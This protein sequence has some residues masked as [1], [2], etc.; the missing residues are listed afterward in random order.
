M[1]TAA[2]ICYHTCKLKNG[3]DFI[4]ENIPFKSGNGSNQWL[5]EGFYFWTDSD[6]WAK[7]W[8]HENTRVIGKF[9]VELCN[10]KELLDLVGN[11]NHQLHFINLKNIILKKLKAEQ[12][13]II[14]INQIIGLLREEEDV[15]PY[16]AVKAQDGKTIEKIHFVD[17]SINHSKLALVTRQQLCV[18][19][20]AKNRIKLCGFLEPKDFHVKMPAA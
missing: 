3:Y 4:V 17:P 2:Q 9:E 5:T 14:T 7:K 8:G 20:Q 15:F 18:F 1:S 19:E 12:K 6:Y 11:V 16:L 13:S 10:N